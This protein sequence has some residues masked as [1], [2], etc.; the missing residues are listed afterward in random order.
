MSH[1]VEKECLCCGY[2]KRKRFSKT[3][4]ENPVAL[5]NCSL[6]QVATSVAPQKF[7]FT[8]NE[9]LN[10]FKHVN[11][12]S[13]LVARQEGYYNVTLSLN[14]YATTLPQSTSMDVWF[15][16]NGQ[17]VPNT[18]QKFTLASILEY[19]AM[20]ISTILLMKAGDIL[21][22]NYMMSNAL[23]DMGM[24]AIPS[25]ALVPATPSAK[26]EV[27]YLRPVTGTEFQKFHS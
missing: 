10:K 3:I 12:T 26:M 11:G 18:N 7:I 22:G 15:T 27:S 14:M 21:E 19:K 5:I 9:Y 25:S 16:L 23:S 17:N 20:Q 6:P 4:V 2:S 8:N 24:Y 1:L 13:Q